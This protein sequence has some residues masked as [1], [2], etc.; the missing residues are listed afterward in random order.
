VV[1]GIAAGGISHSSNPIAPLFTPRL[2]RTSCRG[3]LDHE[4]TQIVSLIG[5]EI[6]LAS[7]TMNRDRLY[8]QTMVDQ[9]DNCRVPQSI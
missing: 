5:D 9:S 8:Y 6:H 7:E 2:N 4:V 3:D 1:C